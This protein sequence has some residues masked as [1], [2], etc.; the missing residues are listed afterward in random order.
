MNLSRLLVWATS[1]LVTDVGDEMCWEMLA[2]VLAVFV[3][4][5]LYH[6]TWASGINNQKI[7]PVSKLYH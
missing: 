3:T 1:M 4:N 6:L 5:I 2:A 7:S